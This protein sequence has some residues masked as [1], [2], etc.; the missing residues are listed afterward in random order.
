MKVQFKVPTRE[1]VSAGNQVLFDQ[2]KSAVGMV[3]N[4]YATIAYSDTALGNYLALQN[5]KTSLSKKEKEVVNL[6]VSQTNNC[7]Y[8][9]AAHTLL[10]KMNGL[11]EEQTLEIRKGS[12]PFDPRLDA[13]VKFTRAVADH[14]GRIDDD[15]LAAFFAA[16][17]T[18]GS[19]IDVVVAIAD[20]VVMNY[21]HNI[22]KIPVDFPAAPAL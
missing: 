5:G 21:V 16:G 11:T 17:Y 3:P 6:V 4:L 12:A 7:Q 1:E 10:G 19:M 22:T 9:L 2:L 13:L 8:C 15:V 14:R 20:K 18:K